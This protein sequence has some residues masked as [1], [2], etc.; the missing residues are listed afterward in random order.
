M[1]NKKFYYTALLCGSTLNAN[2]YFT[3][4]SNNELAP[5]NTRYE[6]LKDAIFA[7]PYESLPYY[8]VTKALFGKASKHAKSY[9]TSD[10]ERTL[11]STTDLLGPERG[12]KLL[13]AN[14]ICFAGEWLIDQTSEFSG[15]YQF[16]SR[17]RVIARAS[18]S[19]SGTRQH[20]RRALGLAVKLLPDDLENS[21][22]LNIFTLHT[23]GGVKTKY[24]FD[25]TLDNEPPLG[26]IPRFRDI[27]T[28]LKLR[29]TL[30]K[31]DKEAGSKK[32]SVTFR[33]VAPLASYNEMNPEAPRWIRFSPASSTRVD[34]KDFRDELRVENYPN[35]ELVYY[36]EVGNEATF[37]K[38]NAT[39]QRI[40][41]LVFTDSITSKAC[42]TQ[43]HFAHP[44]N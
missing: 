28:A 35:K 4:L 15:L 24:L 3:D 33:T 37:K 38:S 29:S 2:A 20:E 31:A 18:A 21:P 19:F 12:Q 42:D 7:K 34:R 39:W 13:Q 1:L 5:N 32:P 30:L 27:S 25:L 14:G 6:A 10:A 36:I 8:K 9:L 23:V 22:S 43:L 11:S 17:V 44:K 16:G 40:G 26:R 41:K